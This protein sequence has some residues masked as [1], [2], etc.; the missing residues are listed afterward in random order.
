ME[1]LFYFTILWI[2]KVKFFPVDSRDFVSEV[3]SSEVYSRDYFLGHFADSFDDRVF[4]QQFKAGSF[5]Y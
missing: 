2:K 5:D 4:L 1:L 3:D